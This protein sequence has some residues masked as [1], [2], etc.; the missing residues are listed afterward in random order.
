VSLSAVPATLGS[1]ALI[2]IDT[3]QD[4]LD[5]EPFEIPGTSAAARVLGQVCAAYR[6]RGL[7]I[8]HVVRLY[9]EDGSNAEPFRREQ[10]S[11]ATPLLRPGTP[12]RQLATALL[13]EGGIDLD[14]ELLLRGGAQQVGPSEWVIYKPRWGAFYRTALESQLRGLAVDTLVIGGC[15]FP[16]CP[17]ASVIE[18]SERDF[19]V[20]VIE[21][22][23]SGLDERG[24]REL[25]AIGVRTMSAEGIVAAVDAPP[26]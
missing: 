14:D 22:G 19:D 16:N 13:P 17:R 25:G 12:G 1:S 4:T 20:V 11:G 23:T 5:G 2:T 15:N 7:P 21:D 6:Q 3:Q 8:V 9:L 26:G 10:V 18:A 24:I